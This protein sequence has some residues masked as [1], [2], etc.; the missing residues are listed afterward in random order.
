MSTHVFVQTILLFTKLELFANFLFRPPC[1]SLEGPAGGGTDDWLSGP[2]G[3]PHM[4]AFLGGK[5]CVHWRAGSR[6]LCARCDGVPAY[7]V[8]C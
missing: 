6:L 4:V 2:V 3:F 7:R 5:F 8:P 1:R